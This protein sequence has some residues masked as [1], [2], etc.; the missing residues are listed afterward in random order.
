[1]LQNSIKQLPLNHPLI[2]FSLPSVHNV[3]CSPEQFKNS[4]ALVIFFT[5]NHCPY[6][7]ASE[8]SLRE[9]VAE[10]RETT[11][12]I[13]IN[14]N[15]ASTYPS[16]SF[17]KMIERN[18]TENF[19]WVYLRDETQETALNYCALVTPHYFLFNQKRELVYSGRAVDSP[20]F[21]DRISS[22]E[23][24]DALRDVLSGKTVNNPLTTPIGCSIK[25]KNNLASENCSVPKPF[26][27]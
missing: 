23:L 12:F 21:P 2:H 25:W 8:P 22:Y 4:A 19:P 7:I 20:R 6:V 17:E 5:C 18:N 27:H 11:T 16:D 24:N 1:M 14:S 13:G 15:D 3:L 10:F 9:T 26:G